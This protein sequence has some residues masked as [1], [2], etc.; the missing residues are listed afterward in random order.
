[1]TTWS[2]P[3]ID[4]GVSIFPD[5]KIRPCCL[6]SAQYSKSVDQLYNHQRFDDLKQNDRPESCKICWQNEDVGLPSYRQFFLKKVTP[7]KGIQFLDFRH[8]NL[9]NLKCRYCGPHFSNQWAKELSYSISLKQLP[10]DK[11]LDFLLGPELHDLYWCGGEPLILQDHYK[12]LHRLI[13]KNLAKQINLRYNTN[14]TS[15]YYKDQDIFDLWKHFK[16]VKLS[17]SIDAAGKELNYIRSGSD[18]NKISSNVDYLLTKIRNDQYRISVSLAPTVS[19]I[20]VWF[21][22][23][24]YQYSQQKQIQ[25]FPTILNGP[26]YLS[27]ASLYSDELIAMAKKSLEPAKKWIGIDFYNQMFS[28]AGHADNESLFFHAVRHIL[29]LDQLRDEKLFNLMPFR[30]IAVKGT[31][32]N[33]EYE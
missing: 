30:H 4:H 8:T 2:C 26:D 28:L 3:A 17:L 33:Y 7:A 1:M 18:W 32:F 31:L 9:C 15:I 22:A 27:L 11:H 25:I 6:T 29:M 16:S 23:D 10:I 12:V 24:L 14:F 5:G 19:L 20:S 21:L 13:D